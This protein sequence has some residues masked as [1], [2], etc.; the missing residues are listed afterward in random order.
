MEGSTVR[1]FP[2]FYR[3]VKGALPSG[4]LWDAYK[5]NLAISQAMLR[6]V[7]MPPG[8]P[9]A[10][11]D[12]LRTALARLNNDKEYAEESMK[13]MQFVP[14]YQT[15]ANINARVRKALTVSPEV[16]SFVLDYVKRGGK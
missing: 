10:A 1:T 15:G 13:T 8:V 2:D 3:S 7:V 9:Q 12:S 16:R 14:F 5:A 6:T 11:A 4:H